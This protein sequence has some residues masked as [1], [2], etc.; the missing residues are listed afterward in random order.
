M[1]VEELQKK[2]RE[3]ESLVEELRAKG[4]SGGGGPS[5]QKIEQM[6]AEVVDANPYRFV[7]GILFKFLLI[8]NYFSLN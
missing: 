3:L 7:V 5:R 8:K 2:V 6:S 4:T 1:S